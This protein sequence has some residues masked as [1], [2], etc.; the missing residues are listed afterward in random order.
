MSTTAPVERRW[1]AEP[2]RF[3]TREQFARLRE[4][5]NALGFSEPDICK[6]LGVETIHDATGTLDQGTPLDP[7]VLLIRLFLETTQASWSIVRSFFSAGDLAAIE[8]LGLLTTSATDPQLCESTVALYPTEGLFIAS[9]RGL[10]VVSPNVGG[11]APADVVFPAIGEA[12]QRFLSLMPRTPCGD[13]LELCSGTGIAALIGASRFADQAWAVDITERSTR[14]ARFNAAL[15]DISNVTALEGDLYDPIRGR[16][17]DR[18]VA[19]PPYVPSFTDEFIFRDAGEDGERVTW[20]ILSGVPAH[21]RPGGEFYCC[22]LASDREGAPLEERVRAALG[23]QGPE[24]DVFVAEGALLDPTIYYARR[25]ERGADT[26]ADVE[27]RL[28][29]FKRLG[30]GQFVMGAMLI[31]RRTE[32]GSRPAVTVRRQVSALTRPR[33][34]QS[35]LSWH[36]AV[37]ESESAALSSLLRSRVRS[38]PH[39]QVRT[40]QRKHGN[41]WQVERIYLVTPGPF[42]ADASCPPAYADVFMACDGRLTGR[43]LLRDLKQRGVLPEEA[44]EADFAALLKRLVEYGLLEVEPVADV[45]ERVA[46]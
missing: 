26:F 6:R 44:P 33:D 4:V 23:D 13:F 1:A 10:G 25:A 15:N 38:N 32:G 21:L 5:L 34:L 37:A 7:Q 24:F 31:R 22:C 28:K 17:F 41:E 3:G 19:N 36:A 35:L 27:K 18:I 29:L 42:V 39:A 9:D 11:R 16:T 8:D 46:D 14:F 43:E 45:A 20:K 12:T 30:I 40:V 2:F